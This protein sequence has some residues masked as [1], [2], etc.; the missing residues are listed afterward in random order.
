VLVNCDRKAE[1]ELFL[2][3]FALVGRLLPGDTVARQ[4]GVLPGDVVVAVNG[5]GF[6]RFKPDYKPE[7]AKVLTG[8]GN[9]PPDL[10]HAVVEPGTGYEQLL[11][12]IKALKASGETF[13]L[14]LERYG[15]D[16]RPLS[17]F[18]FL[19]ARD[20]NV[21]D[22]MALLQ[23]HESWKTTTFPIALQTPGLQAI[24]RTKAVSE[25][26]IGAS[27]PAA[28]AQDND[29][30]IGGGAAGV[31]SVPTVYVNYAKLL[32]LQ[33]SGDVTGDDVVA[34][35]VIFTER[36]LAR[37]SDVRSPKTTQFIDLSG[38]SLSVSG[39]RVD[40]LKKIYGVFEPNYPET[41]HKMVMYPVSSVL[42]RSLSKRFFAFP[43]FFL[44]PR[45]AML[46]FFSFLCISFLARLL[47][48]SPAH[49]HLSLPL[50]KA[51]TSRTM[52][53]FVNERTQKKF[54][55]TNDLGAVC[56]QL[57]WDRTEIEACG[58][59]SEFMHKHEKAGTPMIVDADG[60]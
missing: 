1:N 16:A 19:Q 5:H 29:G 56:D 59:I 57:G 37:N 50:K 7:N 51:T 49:S 22:A 2:P 10:D 36:M 25:I 39:F 24:L 14:T 13:T 4:A 31:V 48:L 44:L 23:A 34:A 55:I 40:T 58:G 33:T 8:G 45:R 28:V 54:L 12:K 11:A 43:S 21:M 15:W 18:R 20:G 53:S 17:W 32:E 27:V 9:A 41:L 60:S 35:F 26:D 42:V 52:L 46:H 30:G 3:G 47:S 38:V 6:R